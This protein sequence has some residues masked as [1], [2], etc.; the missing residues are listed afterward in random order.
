VDVLGLTSY[1]QIRGVLTVSQTDL[2]DELLQGFGVE[3]DLA[4]HLAGWAPDYAAVS[5]A[6]DER[7]ARL[8]RLF[9]KYYCASVIARTAPV[10][11]L[12]KISDGSNEGQRSGEGLAH[13]AT[14]LLATAEKYRSDYE[15]ALSG[16]SKG[17]TIPNV[18][19]R[20]TP[21]R[22]PVTEAREDVS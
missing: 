6:G 1:A 22:D 3:D 10:F 4:E 20:V 16:A 9:A 14:S 8:L 13:L 7:K 11:V 21:S 17:V 18:I 19:S 5:V 2:P 15:D 12:T